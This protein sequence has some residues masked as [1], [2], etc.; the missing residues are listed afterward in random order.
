MHEPV[1][2]P[3]VFHLLQHVALVKNC[4]FGNN[5]TNNIWNL[6]VDMEPSP[7]ATRR[8]EK[9]RNVSSTAH[10]TAKRLKSEQEGAVAPPLCSP[11][12][13]VPLDRLQQPITLNELT[14]LLHY[15][16]L[17]KTGGIQQPSWCRLHHQRKVKG[18]NVVIV[19][20]LTQTHFYKHYLT[21]RH[22][23]TNYSSRITFT[24]PCPER[25]IWNLQQ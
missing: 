21:L 12:I 25:G 7:A 6:S 14:E 23:R 9:R 15:A 18:V 3:C 16:A 17:G 24:P 20:G 5:R 13:S 2:Q 8:R 19:E 22:L 1:Q 10:H 11:R 4:E